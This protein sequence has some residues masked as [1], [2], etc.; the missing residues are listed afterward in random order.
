MA[1]CSPVL[2][3]WERPYESA[4]C[5]WCGAFISAGSWRLR[6]GALRITCCQFCALDRRGLKPPVDEGVERDPRAE[7]LP[8]GDR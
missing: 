1:R 3:R 8:V 2:S 6:V 5:E 7:A 4:G